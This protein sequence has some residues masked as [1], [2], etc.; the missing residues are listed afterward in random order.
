[1]SLL[2]SGKSYLLVAW[3]SLGC[4]SS[5]SAA[6]YSGVA[7]PNHRPTFE[8]GGRRLGYVANRKSD[9]VSVLDLDA[10]TLL[11]NVLVGRDPVDIDGPRHVVIDS[12]AGLA[13]L[14]LSYPYSQPGPH[15]ISSG[16]TQRSGY[17]EALN[18][19]D[20]SEA[21]D[22]RVDP[23]ATEIAFSPASGGLAVAHFDINLALQ[24]DVA[25]RRAN[26]VL[27]E[28]AAAIATGSAAPR[29]VPV[30]A[31][32]AA[33]A[34]DAEGGRVF[35]ACTGEDSLTVVDR[36]TDV[37]LSRVPA[38]SAVVNK[39][40][41]LVADPARARLLVSNQVAFAVSIFDMND[42]PNLLST[43]TVPG[44]PMFPAWVSDTTVV[45]PFQGPSG[46]ALFDARTGEQLV[47]VEYSDADCMNPAEFS[48][49]SDFRLRLVCEGDHYG[50]GAVVLVDPESL[51]I[52]S[53]VSVEIYPERMGIVEP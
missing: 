33:V 29:R 27:V 10:M 25:S 49:T 48:Q 44:L 17:V 16:A 47:Q 22:L 24:A 13:Y 41:A 43:L 51:A 28:P 19:L 8:L 14:A 18:L 42:A 37:V 34:F 4:S 45:V 23:N 52:K 35:V 38:G 5:P 46:A 30:C 50:P 39:P 31:A 9:S 32:P 21:G 20:L 26:L 40:Y 2:Q 1:M 6:D 11:G 53:T 12:A 3:L 7:Y 15:E 36:R